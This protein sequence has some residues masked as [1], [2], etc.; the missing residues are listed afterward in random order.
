MEE[1]RRGGGISVMPLYLDTSPLFDC[2]AGHSIYFN[3]LA[4]LWIL[5]MC[6]T[7]ISVYTY[8]S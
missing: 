7:E 8:K 3:G 6:Y 5:F 1:G 2:T 4:V